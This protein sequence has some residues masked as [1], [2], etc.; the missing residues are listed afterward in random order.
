MGY[1]KVKYALA[2]T[3]WMLITLNAVVLDDYQ[4][5]SSQKMGDL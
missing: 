5:I 2:G 3:S 1:R 4:E